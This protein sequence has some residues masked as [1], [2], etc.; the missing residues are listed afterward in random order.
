MRALVFLTLLTSCD[1]VFSLHELHAD[2]DAG[3]S[4]G[5]GIPNDGKLAIDAS[6][7]S[8]D[9]TIP[10]NCHPSGATVGQVCDCIYDG[11]GCASGTGCYWQWAN[12]PVPKQAGGKCVPIGSVAI[13]GVCT[14][15]ALGP[16][17]EGAWCMWNSNSATTGT[18]N[19]RK[20]CDPMVGGSC[21]SGTC[22]AAPYCANPS[23]YPNCMP[24]TSG[25]VGYCQ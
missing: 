3:A 21:S 4:N 1:W 23:D 25:H 11:L 24:A 6:G 5:D 18:G 9:A 14:I 8:T 17:V 16:C 12:D 10:L 15:N 20:V 13:G 22:I 2:I 19:C 7:S